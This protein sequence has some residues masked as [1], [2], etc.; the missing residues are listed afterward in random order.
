VLVRAAEATGAAWAEERAAT[1]SGQ[2]RAIVGGFPGTLSE[3]RE[4][5]MRLVAPTRAESLPRDVLQ[6]L[7][8]VTYHTAKRLWLRHSVREKHD[9]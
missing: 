6:A 9:E 8:R 3:A 4:R 7:V 2:G 5:L 1:L